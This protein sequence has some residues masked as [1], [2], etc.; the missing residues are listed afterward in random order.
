MRLAWCALALVTFWSATGQEIYI[1][2][3]G[4]GAGRFGLRWTGSGQLVTHLDPATPGPSGA[5]S[6]Q[7]VLAEV[8][9][10]TVGVQLRHGPELRWRVELAVKGRFTAGYAQVALQCNDAQGQQVDWIGLGSVPEQDDWH[11]IRRVVELP[12]DA[13]FV[14]LLVAHEHAQGESWVADVTVAPFAMTPELEALLTPAGPRRWGATQYLR[15]D[16]PDLRD[17]GA[18]LLMAAGVTCTRSGIDWRRAEPE[19]GRYD[20]SSLSKTLDDLAYYGAE[21]AVVFIHGTPS[22][23]SGKTKDNLTDE[24]KARGPYYA[25]RAFFPPQDWSAW[26]R[27]VKALVTEFKGRV[28]VWEICNEPD[29]WTEG[30]CG[31]YDDYVQYLTRAAKVIRETD[32][33]AKVACAAFVFDSWL[34]RLLAD[35]H[36]EAF[37]AACI[38]PYHSLP[39]GTLSRARKA[40]FE[41]L[42]ANVD[43]PVLVTEVGYQSGGWQQGPGV[44]AN[45]EEK[46]TAGVR[47]LE[48]LRSA[49]TLLTWYTAIERGNM[50][51][52]LRDDG[53]HYTPMPMYYAYGKLTGKLSDDESPFEILVQ[54]PEKLSPGQ[55]AEVALTVVNRALAPQTIKLWP[56]GFVTA[57]GVEPATVAAADWQGRLAP[58]E[59]RRATLTIRPVATAKGNYPLGLAVIGE[60][61]N[62]LRLHDV[63]VAP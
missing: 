4:Q 28:P 2:D 50:Y 49:S 51:G 42:L 17:T 37:D 62:G 29:L 35:G 5:P 40:Q 31:T 3:F 15:S 24:Q 20:F 55:A 32:P 34:G 61:W 16:Q 60:A 21:A 47:A 27:F 12:A 39:D 30:F 19:P 54:A 9:R 10:G 1:S 18:K 44:K 57:L 23:A 25:D 33:Q 26:E 58:G 46:A 59:S 13:V 22:W 7:T 56:V 14:N 48:L 52:L 36:G 41:L 6:F 45:E 8:S 53:D 43:R 38:H 11:L 63:T